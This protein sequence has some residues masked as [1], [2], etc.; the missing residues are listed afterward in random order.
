[1]APGASTA[2]P[3]RRAHAMRMRHCVLDGTHAQPFL[4]AARLR[5]VAQRKTTPSATCE[6]AA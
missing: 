1:M 6:G 3:T 2:V 4:P 5:R